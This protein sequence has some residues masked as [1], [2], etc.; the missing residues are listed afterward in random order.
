MKR[1]TA[2]LLTVLAVIALLTG[3]SSKRPAFVGMALSDYSDK[4]T[5]AVYDEFKKLV[6]N[7]D[8][9]KA[10]NSIA[11]FPKFND[12]KGDNAIQ[13]D[14]L[15]VIIEQ[16]PDVLCIDFIDPSSADKYLSAAAEKEIPVI[17]FGSAPSSDIVNKY[18]GVIL[19]AND[20]SDSAKIAK[21][22]Y[23]ICA[24]LGDKKEALDSTGYSFESDGHTLKIA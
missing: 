15:D 13:S 14:Q 22:I 18:D 1:F 20:K 17:L 7:E 21:A 24:N 5:A 10:L 3:C 16:K 2:L 23:D 11:I 9:A 6:E 19:I 4:N 8:N 12:G